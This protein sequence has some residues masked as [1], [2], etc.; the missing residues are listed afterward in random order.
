MKKARVY[1]K[2]TLT[3]FARGILPPEATLM[4]RNEVTAATPQ[5]S[6]NKLDGLLSHALKST[7][8][9]RENKNKPNIVSSAHYASNEGELLAYTHYIHDAVCAYGEAL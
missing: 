7:V 5:A 6:K 8:D 4:M 9:A 2:M 1:A 3:S